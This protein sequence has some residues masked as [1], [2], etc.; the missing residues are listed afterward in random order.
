M[1]AL[2][3]KDVWI[4]GGLLSHWILLPAHS[5]S[6]PRKPE[7]EGLEPPVAVFAAIKPFA[8]FQ[9]PAG[10]GSRNEADQPNPEFS[11]P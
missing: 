11:A 7:A 5:S 1:T 9:S 2:S 6:G 4:I 8:L 3:G 10:A